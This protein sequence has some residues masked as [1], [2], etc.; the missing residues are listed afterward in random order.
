M[1]PLEHSGRTLGR[2]LSA[3]HRANEER[4]RPLYER[5]LSRLHMDVEHVYTVNPLARQSAAGGLAS[6]LASALTSALASCGS[7]V[8]D[9]EK[10]MQ[11]EER[12]MSGKGIYCEGVVDMARL[13]TVALR[14]M[15]TDWDS[16]PSQLRV[17][18]SMDGHLPSER[19]ERKQH[20]ITNMMF[21]VAIQLL[22]LGAQP[23]RGKRSRELGHLSLIH[24]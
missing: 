13:D 23:Q 21:F 17:G 15:C 11:T 10:Q 1:P 22:A 2:M 14:K 16:L 20:Q 7:F 19:V 8:V 5:A 9:Q 18:G 12:R 6:G 4:P 24:I 3:D